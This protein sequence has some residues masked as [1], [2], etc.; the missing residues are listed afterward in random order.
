MTHQF[1][2]Q[3][4]NEEEVIKK[5][6]TIVKKQELGQLKIHKKDGQIQTEYTYGANPK[7][8]KGQNV[9][10]YNDLRV[11]IISYNKIIKKLNKKT[12]CLF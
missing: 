4:K 2:Q 6:R 12:I 11:N 7:R 3:L 10:L 1:E 9:N 8:Y 5:A